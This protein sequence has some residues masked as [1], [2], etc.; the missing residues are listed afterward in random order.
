MGVVR[1]RWK[2]L[3]A[4]RGNHIFGCGIAECCPDPVECRED[5]SAVVHALGRGPAREL[6]AR[7][8]RLDDLYG[9]T[10]DVF[11]PM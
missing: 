10:D 11:P 6:R 8:G 1:R 9:F 5:L 2:V 3:E 4:L 7:I